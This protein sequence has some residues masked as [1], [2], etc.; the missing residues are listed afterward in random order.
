MKK[1]IIPALLLLMLLSS[2]HVYRFFALNVADTRDGKRFPSRRL[3]A[4]PQTN[5]RWTETATAAKLPVIPENMNP[6]KLSF[7]DF[8]YSTKT[9]AFLLIRNDSILFERYYHGLNREGLHPA[10]S[11]AKSF[12]S[13]LVGIAIGEGYMHSVNDPIAD[14]VPGLADDVGKIT[15]EQLLNMRSGL[16]FNEGYFNPFGEIAKFYYGLNLKRYVAELKMGGKPGSRFSY[17]SACTQ[18]LGMAVS[19]ASGR[20]L[21]DY[22]SDKLWQ[23]LGMENDASWNIDSK[24]NGTEKAFC[25]LNATARDYA[26]FGRLYLKKGEWEGKQIIASEWVERSV[27]PSVP[28]Q[29]WYSYQWWLG[30][31]IFYTHGILGQYILVHPEKKIILVRLG[32]QEGK[33]DWDA[34]FVWLCSNL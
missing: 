11:T 18:L 4:T 7:E 13:A 33:A 16:Q 32:N 15:L 28:G 3:S 2:C 12:V 31:G 19:N 14:Y 6:R 10:F 22:A 27:S 23:P 30:E 29:S 8:L 9:T 25:C 26:R 34:F 5:F 17:L 24:K 20:S 21:A 1:I